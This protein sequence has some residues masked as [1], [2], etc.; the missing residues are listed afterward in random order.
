MRF[1][2]KKHQIKYGFAVSD[3]SLSLAAISVFMVG[4]S[5]QVA[6]FS[7]EKKLL[8]VGSQIVIVDNAVDQF[9]RDRSEILETSLQ[10][11]PQ[12]ISIQNLKDANLLPNSFDTAAMTGQNFQTAVRRTGPYQFEYYTFLTGGTSFTD[13]DLSV[14]VKQ[15]G[16]YG[17]AVY[18]GDDE[19]FHARGGLLV[20]PLD[21]FAGAS[22]P[23]EGYPAMYNNFFKQAVSTDYLGKTAITGVPERNTMQTDLLLGGNNLLGV[24]DADVSGNMDVDGQLSAGSITTGGIISAGAEIQSTSA[25]ALR[26]VN[27]PYGTIIRTD[28]TRA[29]M[30]VTDSGNQYG[31][32]NSLRPYTMELSTGRTA[33]GTSSMYEQLTLNGNMWQPW[34]ATQSVNLYNSGGTWRYAA[35]GYG[36][37]NEISNAQGDWTYWSAP[38]N[39]AGQ[40]AVANITRELRYDTSAKT[41]EVNG[42]V[43]APNAPVNGNHLTNKDYVDNAI[44]AAA[45]GGGPCGTNPSVG[46]VC[47]DGTVFIG[48]DGA[49]GKNIYSNPNQ[50][51]RVGNFFTAIPSVNFIQAYGWLGSPPL[52]PGEPI[53]MIC[54]YRCLS[55]F[56]ATAYPTSAAGYCEGLTA[57]G[58]D[59]WFLPATGHVMMGVSVGSAAGFVHPM[60]SSTSVEYW[61]AENRARATET[62]TSQGWRVGMSAIQIN[63][64]ERVINQGVYE[65]NAT[66]GT[67]DNGSHVRT[68][69]VRAE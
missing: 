52:S 2:S 67:M 57:L 1:P 25:N 59:D 66:K 8:Q 5:E 27:G 30:L 62:E 17:G 51:A 41:L 9:V 65:Y 35:N 7:Y 31:L 12:N 64:A 23:T 18:S 10:A 24:A 69:C 44:A 33:L 48:V 50:P 22:A 36:G 3:V 55:K 4:M 40:G 45:G 29:Y 54:G 6:D 63:H 28:G 26:L 34:K 39:T 47:T 38:N 13:E 42:Y 20:E 53:G 68:M 16:A 37:I 21:N 43:T 15:L 46:E 56:V 32:W 58:Y 60:T 14:I 49:T 19:N 11:G 61:A